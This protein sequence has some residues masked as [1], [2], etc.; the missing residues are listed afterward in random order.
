MVACC[1]W[2]CFIFRTVSAWYQNDT[3]VEW[4]WIMPRGRNHGKVMKLA[5]EWPKWTLV[6]DMDISLQQSWQTYK[7][8]QSEILYV[9]H[10]AERD[11]VLLRLGSDMC[12]CTYINL[13]KRGK[14][15]K[16][17]T[18]SSS[19]VCSQGTHLCLQKRRPFPLTEKHVPTLVTGSV[20]AI[21]VK[22]LKW[23][24]AWCL[25]KAT[26]TTYATGQA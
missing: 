18:D 15:R 23:F 26:L 4:Y 6:T 1:I 19:L 11:L 8:P 17:R 13:F 3:E 10:D 21:T 22:A 2:L 14:V 7:Y 9:T 12:P 20:G 24:G 5:H 16:N 25:I